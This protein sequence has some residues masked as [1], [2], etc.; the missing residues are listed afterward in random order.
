LGDGLYKVR[1]VNS[2]TTKGQ[3]AGS[4]VIYYYFD[5]GERLYLLTL[6]AKNELDTIQHESLLALLGDNL[7]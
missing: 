4:R 6:Y 5:G 2:A 1:R 3:R 7:N